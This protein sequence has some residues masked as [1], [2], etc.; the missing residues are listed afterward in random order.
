MA[1]T[2]GSKV[3]VHYV[4]TLSNGEKFDSSRDRNEE[5]VFETGVNAMIQGFE[6]TILEMNV[7]DVKTVNIKSEEAYGSKREDLIMEVETSRLPE[8]VQVGSMLDTTDNNGNPLIVK[9]AELNSSKNEAGEDLSLLDFNHPLAGE[10]L[11]FEIELVSVE[12]P[13]TEA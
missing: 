1:V 9:V 6:N 7:G 13:T 4:G 5:L 10:D 2:K 11:T 8:G 12:E 3:S